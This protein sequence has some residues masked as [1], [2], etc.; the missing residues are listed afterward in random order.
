M[1]RMTNTDTSTS[2]ANR[3]GDR[4]RHRS[5]SG[6]SAFVLVYR[7][8]GWKRDLQDQMNGVL[9]TVADFLPLPFVQTDKL[10]VLPFQGLEDDSLCY[11]SSPL[12]LPEHFKVL[13]S[14]PISVFLT[15]YEIRSLWNPRD[16]DIKHNNSKV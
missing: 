2:E 11:L 3:C 13:K 16:L 6:A 14:I 4:L 15:G 1:L 8:T 12:F 9:N 10:C 7:S 5:I